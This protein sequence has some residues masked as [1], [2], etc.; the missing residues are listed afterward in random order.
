MS[1]FD[2][3]KNA[4]VIFLLVATMILTACSSL[5]KANKPAP[6]PEAGSMAR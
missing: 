1:T 2:S 3:Y 5:K 6:A 4:L